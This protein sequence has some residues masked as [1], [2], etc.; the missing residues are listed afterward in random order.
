M[1]HTPRRLTNL[2]GA[3]ENHYPYRRE[4][5][6]GHIPDLLYSLSIGKRIY[7]LLGEH[8]SRELKL[9]DSRVRGT[10]RPNEVP[11]SRKNS[12]EHASRDRVAYDGVATRRTAS[13]RSNSRGE[14]ASSRRRGAYLKSRRITGISRTLHDSRRFSRAR[15][16]RRGERGS[17]EG[18]KETEHYGWEEPARAR[19][20][21]ARRKSRREDRTREA[22]ERAR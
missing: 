2:S 17:S 16:G 11:P 4:P 7:L 19:V 12:R 13:A 9:T 6:R 5:T 22:R 8:A 14:S 21:V 18:R 20:K 1:E 3:V 10:L 15:A